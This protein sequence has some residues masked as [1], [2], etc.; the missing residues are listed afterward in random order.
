MKAQFDFLGL[1]IEVESACSELVEETQRDFS[2]FRAPD[3][4]V[5]VHI[6]LHRSPPPFKGLPAIPASFST[7]RNICFL[8][9]DT[10]YID[11]FGRG[12]T[13]YNR[14]QARCAVYGEDHDLVHE[15]AY[16][17][18]L[19]TV[20]KWLDSRRV[21]RLH[22]LG[23]SYR[24]RGILLL[25]SSGGGKSTI[26]LR[27]LCEPGFLLLSEDTPLIDR[28]GQIL[29]FP[30]R[31]GV[32]PE[33]ETGIPRQY[34]RTMKRMEFDPKT[35]IDI[36]YFR[37]RLG[38]ETPPAYL[39]V[40]KR[41]LGEISEIVPLGR[42]RTFQALLNNMIVGLGVYQGLEFLLERGI[43]ELVSKLGVVISRTY[44]SL[45]LL[46]STKAY[47]FILGRD[48]DRNIQTVLTFLEKNVD[49][50]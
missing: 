14:K 40:G 34:L 15:I 18:I 21:H 3:G 16:L 12:L 23:V 33:Q 35:L 49:H 28:R 27:L 22:A 1:R 6:E 13:I 44:N 39:L 25:L 10:S 42:L 4:P 46:R 7:P 29:P 8:D 47:R 24:N 45:L 26:A 50:D 5:E 17:F 30:L 19:S 31:I 41:N 43:W 37:D 11:Y 38:T 36:E 32:H 48:M 9:N 20:G 2:Y